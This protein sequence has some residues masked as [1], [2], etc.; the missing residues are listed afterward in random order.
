M[1]Q[2]GNS[3]PGQGQQH[4]G[5]SRPTPNQQRRQQGGGDLPGQQQQDQQ[6]PDERTDPT[7]RPGGKP[8]VEEPNVKIDEE[9]NNRIV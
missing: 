5:Q 9:D 3:Q 7:R 6:A 1:I 2:Q 8:D 4:G